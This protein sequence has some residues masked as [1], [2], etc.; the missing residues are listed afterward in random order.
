MLDTF[1]QRNNSTC[2]TK[3]EQE[4]IAK[5][6]KLIDVLNTGD[7]KNKKEII[8]DEYFNPESNIDLF[9][10]N[11]PKEVAKT[12]EQGTKLRGPKEFIDTMKSVRNAFSDLS[13]KEQEI[14]AMDNKVFSRFII[15]GIHTGFFFIFPQT[16]NKFSYQAVHIHRFCNNKIIEHRA[17]RDD[18]AFMMQLDIVFP[19]KQY[20]S[21]FNLWKGKGLDIR[22]SKKVMEA[23]LKMDKIDIKVLKQAYDHE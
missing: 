21:L 5:V 14:C 1:N 8:H 12:I 9:N 18:L 19:K 17:I 15:S 11:L 16:G 6:R 4:N 23:M 2:N 7:M 20:E 22:K 3:K 10:I 13:Y